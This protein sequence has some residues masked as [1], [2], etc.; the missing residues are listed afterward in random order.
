MLEGAARFG[1]I[2]QFF[3]YCQLLILK[4]GDFSL[5]GVDDGITGCFDDAIQQLVYLFIDLS[6]LK[7]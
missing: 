4:L 7:T 3:G 1:T 5:I 6:N 2:F